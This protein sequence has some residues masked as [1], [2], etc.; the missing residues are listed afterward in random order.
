M[1]SKQLQ[2]PLS[3][4]LLRFVPTIQNLTFL[5]I[6]DSFIDVMV[7]NEKISLVIL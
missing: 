2:F 6:R 7:K 1:V 5:N 4:V 3:G